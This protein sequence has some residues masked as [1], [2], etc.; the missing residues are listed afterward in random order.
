MGATEFAATVCYALAVLVAMAFGVLYL[1][2]SRFMPYH[3]DALQLGWDELDSQLQ[4]L[5]LA[6]MRGVGG[7]WLAV[8]L[9]VAFL[10]LFPFRAGETWARYAIP[11]V[12]LAAALPSLYAGLYV[13]S[14]TP[15]SPPVN[16]VVVAVLLLI[17]GFF[18]SLV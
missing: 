15:A 3:S 2:R 7:G 18:I 5:L 13:R 4:A 1:T 8:S 12:G 11:L 16:L 17:V 9:S 6:L 10:L 14:R